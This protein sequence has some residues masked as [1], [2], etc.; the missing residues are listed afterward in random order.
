MKP[1]LEKFY[2]TVE[3]A[4]ESGHPVYGPEMMMQ[5]LRLGNRKERQIAAY[6]DRSN[7][8]VRQ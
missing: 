2:D 7:G 1:G 4:M 8:S 6:I 3:E 5:F